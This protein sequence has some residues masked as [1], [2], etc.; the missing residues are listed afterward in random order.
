MTLTLPDWWW[1]GAI[2][3]FL[4][5]L[6]LIMLLTWALLRWGQKQVDKLDADI[7]ALNANQRAFQEDL[8]RRMWN[9]G[10]E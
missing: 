1:Q 10:G 6:A 8:H 3:G 9:D 4:I 2:A 5:F 7:T